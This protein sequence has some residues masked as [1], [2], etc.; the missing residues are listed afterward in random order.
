MRFT[1]N[2]EQE[3]LRST[4]RK[5][6]DNRYNVD[7]RRRRVARGFDP[8][9][10]TELA[11]LG[12]LGL[13]FEEKYGGS[14]GSALHT[15]V[16]MEA[17]GR[18]LVIEPYIASIVLG[19]GLLR[20][21]AEERHKAQFI[22]RLVSGELRLALA[23]AE[24]QSRFHL[25]SVN[26]RARRVAGDFVLTGRK[27]VVQGAPDCHMLLVT[28]RTSGNTL[29]RDGVS[30]FLIPKEAEGLEIRGYTCIDG[31]SAA[32]INMNDVHVPRESLVGEPGA[33]LPAVEQVVDEAI[34][35]ICG[36]AVGAMAALIEKCVA[37]AKTR[38][39]FGKPIG[40]FQAIGHRLVDMHVCYEQ[41]SA[42]A[43][44]A[45]LKLSTSSTNSKRTI[46]ACKV[47]VGKEAAFVGK[48][49]VQ[50]HGAMGTTDELDIGHYFKR[51]TA[52]QAT[53]GSTQ[54]HLRRYADLGNLT[55]ETSRNGH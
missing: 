42:I 43:I 10:W 46:S 32:D 33:A 23:F 47:S 24:A 53:F 50:M 45:A 11:Q 5:Y 18:G 36:E 25:P 14:G 35:A 16:V 41:A 30:L 48:S 55:E 31:M 6:V 26:V 22:P 15:L 9:V 2:E 51:L 49:A 29:D 12:V 8:E 17:F 39:A 4:L 28:A 13:P 20:V 38:Q 19:G 40:H 7:Y 1:W 27:I 34:S 52:I 21:A 37:F 44:K 54:Y 3:L